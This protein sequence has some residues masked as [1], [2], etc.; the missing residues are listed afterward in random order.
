MLGVESV[1]AVGVSLFDVLY[2]T[3]RLDP[4]VLKGI[5]HLHHSQHFENLGDLMGYM[6]SHIIDSESGTQA[7]RQMIHKYKGYTGEEQAFDRIAHSGISL[8]VPESGTNPDFDA[9]VNGHHVDFAITD[10]PSY[11][12]DKLDS[13]PN[14]LVWTNREMADAFGDNSRVIVDPDLSSQDAFHATQDSMAGMSDLGDFMHHI[15]LITLVISATRN[16]IGVVRGDKDMS[17]AIE[18]TALDT[19]GVGFGVLLGGNAGMALGLALAPVTGGAS[20]II[21]PAVSTLLGSIIGSFTGKEITMWIKKRHLRSAIEDLSIISTSF[22]GVFMERYEMLT[23]GICNFYTLKKRRCGFARTEAQDWFRRIFFP[24]PLSKFYSMAISRLSHDWEET[25]EF[26]LTLKQKISNMEPKQGGLLLFAQGSAVLNGDP[27]LVSAYGNVER[28]VKQVEAERRKLS[29]I[30]SNKC[31]FCEKDSS[32][33]LIFKTEHWC[34]VCEMIGGG[35]I[36]LCENH[37]DSTIDFDLRH[38]HYGDP[39]DLC[40][41]CSKWRVEAAAKVIAVK[42]ANIEGRKIKQALE[43]IETRH[44]H[45]DAESA[46]WEICYNAHLRG[47]N[48]ILNFSCISHQENNEGETWTAKGNLALVEPTY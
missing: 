10:N 30:P 6:K 24:S 34:A 15:P 13:D 40:P 47:A 44:R 26:Y 3:S 18:H 45:K 17:T 5:E 23:S 28:A 46:K 43:Y 25:H 48:A 37:R 33:G 29:G 1:T 2:S 41:H 32:S 11:I 12:Q 16:T 19:A 22:R 31:H 36:Y 42:S 27:I 14:I 21:I 7:W 4:F 20:A 35:R 39:Y 9:T 8:K 38:E